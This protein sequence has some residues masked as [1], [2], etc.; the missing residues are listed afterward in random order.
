[1]R[2]DGVSAYAP[3]QVWSNARVAARLRL[4]RMRMSARMRASG[5]GRL[6]AEE[7][8]LFQTSDRWVRRFIGFSERRFCGE[9]MGTIDL[10]AR[11][12][13]PTRG[14]RRRTARRAQLATPERGP[15]ARRCW[16]RHAVHCRAR[17]GRLVLAVAVLE[18]AGRQPRRDHTHAG[19]G[20]TA[21]LSRT[22]GA[23][24]GG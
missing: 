5:N 13:R 10:A 16:R 19:G 4:E 18:R 14:R 3:E 22:R 1:M 8:K 23:R 11:A 24:G 2:L 15:R 21:A 17:S 9:G 20:I 6:G 12:A 7:A